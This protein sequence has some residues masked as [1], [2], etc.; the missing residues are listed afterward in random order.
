MS[1]E[2]IPAPART[3]VRHPAAP[4]SRPA[5]RPF[6]RHG[7]LLTIGASLWAA[8]QAL[9]G[10]RAENADHLA[11][12][13]GVGSLVF[14]LGLLALLRVYYRTEALGSGRLARTVLR[15]EAV[16]RLV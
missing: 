12:T 4:T 13:Y 10:V 3:D 9:V 6:F 8:S 2:Q 5:A 15:V 16:S 7:T 14:Q 1:I 11:W